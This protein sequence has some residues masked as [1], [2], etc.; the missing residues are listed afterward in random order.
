M[1]KPVLAAVNGPAVGI[2]CSLALACDL[3]VARESAYFLLAFVNIGL[4]PDGG[5]SVFVPARAGAGRA[6]DDGAARR[7]HPGA[8]GDARGAWSTG[9]S[10][11]DAFDAEVD[12]LAEQLATGRPR[13]TRRPRAAQRV[14][15]RA[16]G[17]AARAGG[18]AAAAEVGVGRLR[19][20]RQ[21][22]LEN[23]APASPAMSCP[24]LPVNTLPSRWPVPLPKLLAAAPGGR[25]ARRFWRRRFRPP[26][27]CSSPSPRR[28]AERRRHP[29]ALHPHLRASG[30]SS[31][32]A[33]R[34]C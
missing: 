27:G 11:D 5:S 24:A 31:S 3:V 29:D 10:A 17:R 23:A 28:V 1:P 8:A 18:V 19:G 25:V 15:V 9:W 12:A 4:V 2:G 22:F 14:G 7:A 34:A 21:A 20:G 16:D 33:S 30:W 13:P 32:S 6:A 26:R